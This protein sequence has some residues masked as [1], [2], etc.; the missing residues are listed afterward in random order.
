MNEQFKVTSAE[1]E[2]ESLSSI[3]EFQNVTTDSISV[4]LS[5][6]R[7]YKLSLNMAHQFIAQL[8]EGIRDAVFGNVGSMAVFRVGNDDAEYL[9]K[10]FEPTFDMKDIANL[11]NWNAY[12]KIL[13]NGQPQDPFNIQTIAPEKGD[14]NIVENLKELSRLK[15]GKKKEII[16]AEILEKYKN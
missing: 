12:L 9:S 6:A 8:N 16:D 11:D 1:K 4:I 13:A 2:P 7:K 5:E 10:Q 15:Y 3:D 14:Q